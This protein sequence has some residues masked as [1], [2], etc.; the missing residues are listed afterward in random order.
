[1]QQIDDEDT[2]ED[3]DV[4]GMRDRVIQEL[5]QKAQQISQEASEQRKIISGIQHA[6]RRD[7]SLRS[8][9]KILNKHS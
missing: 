3:V 7:R 2:E 4:H 5:Q 9:K 6:L 8:P 1:M